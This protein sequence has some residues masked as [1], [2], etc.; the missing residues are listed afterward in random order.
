MIPDFVIFF[1]IK[2]LVPYFLISVSKYL[3]LYVDFCCFFDL[4]FIFMEY[5]FQ[6][7]KSVAILLVFLTY[8]F[9][10]SAPAV[11]SG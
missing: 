10:A 8:H 6:L 4:T 7:S 9:Y 3:D 11:L 5:V 1:K 2:P